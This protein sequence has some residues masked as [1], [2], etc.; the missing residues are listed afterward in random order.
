MRLRSLLTDNLTLKVLSVVLAFGAWLLAQGE[1]VHRITMDVPVRY[2]FPER[3]EGKDE[4]SRLVVMNEAPLPEQVR[5]QVSGTRVAISRFEAEQADLEYPVDL[6]EAKP[7]TVV[8]SFRIP[9]GELG[10]DVV[11]D[12]VSPVEVGIVLDAVESI[13]VPVRIRK[14]GELPQGLTEVGSRVKPEEV[15]LVGSRK[16]L[17]NVDHV[18]TVALRMSEMDDS[19]YLGGLELDLEA[20][21]LLP[22]S[23]REV[24]VTIEV[25]LKLEELKFD[26]I[27]VEVD[28]KMEGMTVSPARC[29]IRVKGPSEVV[30]KLSPSDL[31]AA[32]QGSPDLLDFSTADRVPVMA[33]KATGTGSEQPAVYLYVDHPRAAELSLEAEPQ[34]F[35]VERDAPTDEAQPA[36][37]LE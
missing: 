11:L 34:S 26:K 15:T 32:F 17:A 27:P 25:K 29:R 10:P 16:D 36:P 6:R 33:V 20:L 19:G 2:L 35:V 28:P 5:L 4:D 23:T 18:D 9:P 24:T 22:E 13:T 12:T 1:Q 21:H 14:V 37:G 7:G 8:Y 3:A 30:E 31:R